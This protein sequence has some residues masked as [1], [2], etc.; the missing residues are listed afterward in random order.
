MLEY[1]YNTKETPFSDYK[2]ILLKIENPC[3][4]YFSCSKVFC[5]KNKKEEICQN[6]Y[7]NKIS[8]GQSG[9]TNNATKKF[10]YTAIADRL[11]KVSWS[12]YIH[13]TGVVNQ[14]FGPTFPLPQQPCN[15]M[16]TYL[17]NCE[18]TSLCTQ[19]TNSHTKRR[20]IKINTQT[21]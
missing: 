4:R 19:Q 12:N 1:D 13:P 20:I 16:D 6:P 8:K 9:N 14:F 5:S 17:K 11:R 10:N 2:M 3:D 7:T 18:Y 15:Q 21:A